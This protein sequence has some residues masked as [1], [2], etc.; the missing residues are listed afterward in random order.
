[1]TDNN[2]ESIITDNLSLSKIDLIPFLFKN[3]SIKSIIL[4]SEINNL[5]ENLKKD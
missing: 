3:K 1:M 4:Q 5:H 2:N